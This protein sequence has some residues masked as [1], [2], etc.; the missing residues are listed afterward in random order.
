MISQLLDN[1]YQFLL[2]E[3]GLSQNTV[4]AYSIDLVKFY[5]FLRKTKIQDIKEITPKHIEDFL[6]ELAINGLSPRS[7]ARVLT[8]IKT[9]FRFLIYSGKLDKNPASLIEAPRFPK[10]LPQVLNLTEVERLLKTPDT[11]NPKGLRD[12][13][14]L[15]LLYA[16]GLRVSELVKIK[17]NQIN[18]EAGY[19]LIMGKGSK[20]R[21]IPISRHAQEA[22][23]DYLKKGRP[24]LLGQKHSPYVFLGYKGKPLTRQGFWEII[25]R[26]ALKAGINKSISPHTLRHS[27]ATHL[28]ERGADL[29][30]VQTML[31]HASV[32]TTQIY[33]HI[34]REFLK[35]NY[36]KFHPRAK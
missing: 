3:R 16:T 7:R 11:S 22:I 15:E 5:N 35:R 34:T 4:E 20:E 32:I 30:S 31:G 12:K 27:F 33:T 25:K 17:L 8:S 6:Y 24:Y 2:L 19:V 14:M 28:L 9:F 36:E 23:E 26:Y 10:K 29:R 18:L 1:F 21:L 13:A